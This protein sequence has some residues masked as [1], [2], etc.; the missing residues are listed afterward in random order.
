MRNLTEATL[1]PQSSVPDI[2]DRHA[3][4]IDAA[5]RFGRTKDVGGAVIAII[6]LVYD[7]QD[8]QIYDS[9]ISV[10]NAGPEH[11]AGGY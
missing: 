9:G 8:N 1:L 2:E 11:P 3:V 10:L 6:D 7:E 5:H 4:V